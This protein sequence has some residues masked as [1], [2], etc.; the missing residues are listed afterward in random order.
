M[1][2][3]N[4]PKSVYNETFNFSK[5][6]IKTAFTPNAD[7]GLMIDGVSDIQISSV[8]HKAYIKVDEDGTE[9]AAATG[10]PFQVVITYCNYFV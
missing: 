7:F 9:A 6:G 8:V 3:H 10:N 1:H 2:L 5:I 4:V